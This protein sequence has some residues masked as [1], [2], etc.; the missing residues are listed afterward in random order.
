M[1]GLFLEYIDF[2]FS[3]AVSGL[4]ARKHNQIHRKH[5]KPNIANTTPGKIKAPYSTYINQTLV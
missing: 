1:F 4:R 5:T 2:V 3:G